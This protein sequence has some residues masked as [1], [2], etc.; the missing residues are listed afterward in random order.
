MSTLL[1]LSLAHGWG[2]YPG[3]FQLPKQDAGATIGL[4]CIDSRWSTPNVSKLVCDESSVCQVWS[5]VT[6]RAFKSD[7]SKIT[8]MKM[9]RCLGA[10]AGANIT[11]GCAGSLACYW[12]CAGS[13][14]IFSAIPGSTFQLPPSA[15]EEACNNQPQCLG[16]VVNAAGN[17]GTLL[18]AEVDATAEYN[19]KV[20]GCP[21]SPPSE[22]RGSK[23]VAGLIP[24]FVAAPYQL[25]DPSTKHTVF[26]PCAA[27]PDPA[28]VPGLMSSEAVIVLCAANPELCTHFAGRP[29]AGSGAWSAYT[30]PTNGFISTYFR[31]QNGTCAPVTSACDTGSFLRC[32]GRDSSAPLLRME[33][34]D[35][36][37]NLLAEICLDKG[38]DLFSSN[39]DG[40]GGTLYTLAADPG[41]D[42]YFRIP[43]SPFPPPPP[44]SVKWSFQ[45]G[46]MVRSSPVLSADGS[47]VYVGSD[48][49]NLYAIDAT[50]GIKKWGFATQG[51][52]YS[53]PA[54]SPSGATVYVGSRGGNLYAIDTATGEERWA[55]ATGATYSS[56]SVGLHD[57][58]VETVYVGSLDG[59]LYAIDATTGEQRWKY[60]TKGH[61]Y[62]SRPLLTLDHGSDVH[63]PGAVYI[64][65]GSHLFY[66]VERGGVLAWNFT[67]GDIISASAAISPDGSTV[68]VGSWDK[69]LYAIDAASG[70]KKWSFPMGGTMDAHWQPAFTADGATVYAGSASLIAIDVATGTKKWSVPI[71]GCNYMSPVLSAD[72]TTVYVNAG[73]SLY[74]IDAVSGAKKWSFV[75]GSLVVSSPALSADGSTVYVG[76]YDMKVYALWA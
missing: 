33:H 65:S 51:L 47:T 39:I 59:C 75:A 2:P 76:S 63:G 54:L 32:A 40:S 23:P 52:V 18:T 49:K 72:G 71:D 66:A 7:L 24:G 31:T 27:A 14:G 64:G 61:I 60:D 38:C 37:M 11:G 12:Q 1:T 48:D 34:F 8:F 69:N 3:Y 10:Q 57:G 17:R 35:V 28:Y 55:F 4:G 41:V 74:V 56:P 22:P 13:S 44:G 68:C 6:F 20:P 36:N 73:N 19:L 25:I 70:A 16:F 67:T 53:T 30:L 29:D 43:P 9:A 42:S 21:P 26:G 62:W 58:K 45:T 50:S 5:D 46:G 15:I